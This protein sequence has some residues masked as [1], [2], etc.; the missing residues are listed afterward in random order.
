M[1]FVPAGNVDLK[2]IN[3]SDIIVGNPDEPYMT[4]LI[5]F[6]SQKGF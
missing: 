3:S 6:T 5:F 1:A 2:G 4:S